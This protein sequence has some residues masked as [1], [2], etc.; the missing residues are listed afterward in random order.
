MKAVIIC[1]FKKRGNI[2]L[3][4]NKIK[5]KFFYHEK[6]NNNIVCKKCNFKNLSIFILFFFIVGTL[7][8]ENEVFCINGE[9]SEPN[10][11]INIHMRKRQSW[12]PEQI[13]VSYIIVGLGSFEYGKVAFFSDVDNIHRN[14]YIFK[15]GIY[16]LDGL[17]IL[18]TIDNSNMEDALIANWN[19]ETAYYETS[20]Y[21]SHHMIGTFNI[22][23]K[24]L[25]K[26]SYIISVVFT[27]KY[28][29]N[30]YVFQEVIEYKIMDIWDILLTPINVLSLIIGLLSFYNY[31][32]FKS[33][34]R[35][36]DN[37]ESNIKIK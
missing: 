1:Y 4:D 15:Q 31:R 7:I 11:T 10:Y 21:E 9:S 30:N 12:K 2:N 5:T 14:T 19:I 22:D 18:H 33:L 25:A 16:T 24:N 28:N 27:A 32:L 13:P 3:K 17:K 26:G 23:T 8:I 35:L 6:I 37:I 36:F 34:K 29:E 20:I